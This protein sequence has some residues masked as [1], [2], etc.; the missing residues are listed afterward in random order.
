MD[1]LEG[2]LQTLTRLSPPTTEPLGA[3]V[4]HERA[5]RARRRS[6]LALAVPAAALVVLMVA[7]ALALRTRAPAEVT[8]PAGPP[9]QL[10]AG[11]APG[12]R[13]DELVDWVS[14][15]VALRDELAAE[16]VATATFSSTAK[17]NAAGLARQ[18]ART[19]VAATAFS[20][21]SDRVDIGRE[22][23]SVRDAQKQFQ[24]RIKSLPTIRQSV[25][26]LQ[27]DAPR[28]V[29]SY[30]A[31]ISDLTSIERGLL[32]N[33]NDPSLFRGLFDHVNLTT[34]TNLEAKTA[35]LLT[36]A[37]EI[38]F[39]PAV[40]P[41]AATP[42]ANRTS[43]LGRGCRD[44]AAAAGDDCALYKDAITAN[45]D[46]ADADQ[47]FEEY[48]TAPQKQLKRLSE[49]GLT[50]DQLKRAAFEDGRGYNDLAGGAGTTPVGADA[51]GPATARRLAALATAERQILALVRAP[52][53]PGPTGPDAFPP[54]FNPKTSAEDA[55]TTTTSPLN[56][57][58]TAPVPSTTTARTGG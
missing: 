54:G 12:G 35:A 30:A 11:P 58:T 6:Q 3:D 34:V 40:L 50:Y 33:I 53:G 45:K 26:T 43:A 7:A 16:M 20:A 5:A 32:N 2:R 24:N 18:R 17:S 25:D 56:A 19:D 38:G 52:N 9:D 13:A 8:L 37:V 39:Y 21:Q 10:S 14:R 46:L 36:I 42:R 55:T 1:E 27:T 31:V 41:T 48:A 28:M 4:M 23:P 15:S 51:F 47:N 29:D 22:G 49:V 57:V 44:D